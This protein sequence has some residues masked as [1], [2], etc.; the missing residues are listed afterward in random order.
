MPQKQQFS[1][2]VQY[3]SIT[4]SDWST[5]TGLNQHGSQQR[6]S[7]AKSILTW[8]TSHEVNY[9]KY[10]TLWCSVMSQS[11]RIRGG[12]TD[13]AFKDQCFLWERGASVSELKWTRNKAL[14]GKGKEKECKKTFNSYI[15]YYLLHFKF[16][17]YT[18]TFDNETLEK[19][20]HV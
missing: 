19:I 3:Y 8:Q 5:L 2:N 18:F 6:G 20:L 7:Y 4:S 14:E 17:F 15:I 11:H 16:D 9:T 13:E 10:V 12:A 1:H